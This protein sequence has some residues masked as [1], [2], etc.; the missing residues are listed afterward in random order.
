MGISIWRVVGSPS[1]CRIAHVECIRIRCPVGYAVCVSSR[2]CRAIRWTVA[3]RAY[4]NARS[5]GG[6][7][8]RCS[9]IHIEV[10][11]VNYPA[12]VGIRWVLI[13]EH[14]VLPNVNGFQRVLHPSGGSRRSW[15]VERPAQQNTLSASRLVKANRSPENLVGISSAYRMRSAAVSECV[16]S[17][18]VASVGMNLTPPALR[19]ISERIRRAIWI[20]LVCCPALT[21]VCGCSIAAGG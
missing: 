15:I 18:A 14:G 21:G 19:H 11:I 3:K 6:S 17:Q 4:T 5:A 12:A 2:S 1:V 20:P 8:A 10:T 13:A 9:S 16:V 7:V